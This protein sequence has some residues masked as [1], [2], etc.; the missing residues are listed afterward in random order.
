M[1]EFVPRADKIHHSK[2]RNRGERPS[3]LPDQEEIE[4]V[5]SALRANEVVENR[6]ALRERSAIAQRFLRGPGVDDSRSLPLDHGCPLHA[7][8]FV[9]S[10]LVAALAE[11]KLESNGQDSSRAKGLSNLQVLLV[12]CF[13]WHTLLYFPSNANGQTLV[14]AISIST[15]SLYGLHASVPPVPIITIALRDNV[16]IRRYENPP[17]NKLPRR[18]ERA[19]RLLARDR[20]RHVANLV[21]NPELRKAAYAPAVPG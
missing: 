3:W 18:N 16:I 8:S 15:E 9:R 10:F 19:D 5:E 13:E 21:V 4:V 1:G 2:P 14:L 12:V 20:S 7:D 11:T 6:A 17:L